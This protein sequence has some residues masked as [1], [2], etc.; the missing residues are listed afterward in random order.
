M[1]IKHLSTI[2]VAALISVFV[3]TFSIVK[4]VDNSNHYAIDVTIRYS[5]N[6]YDIY[7]MMAGDSLMLLKT[8]YKEGY[9]FAGWYEDAEYTKEFDFEKEIKKNTTI[10]AK[11]LKA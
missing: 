10:Y 1:K 2:V 9:V 6:S 5:D 7:K 11:M 3:I 8:P 4:I